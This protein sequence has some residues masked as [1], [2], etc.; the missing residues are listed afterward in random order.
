MMKVNKTQT[1]LF[2]V[3]YAQLI[4]HIWHPRYGKEIQK[5][6]YAKWKISSAMNF[7]TR[8]GIIIIWSTVY[9]YILQCTNTLFWLYTTTLHYVPLYYHCVA[10]HCPLCTNSP[11][12]YLC[13]NTPSIMYQYP[14]IMYQHTRGRKNLVILTL[15]WYMTLKN[16]LI[17]KASGRK[18]FGITKFPFQDFNV[19]NTELSFTLVEDTTIT[20]GSPKKLLTSWH[21]SMFTYLIFL[22]DEWTWKKR[23]CLM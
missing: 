1:K 14:I 23:L 18:S 20:L 17:W 5:V 13:A 8:T 12:Y 4:I 16:P 7:Q 10:T 6:F 19:L 22:W 21:K 9:Q 11:I 15:R 3:S 2:H